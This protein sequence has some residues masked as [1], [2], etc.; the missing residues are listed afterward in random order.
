M[1]Y[2]ITLFIISSILCLGCLLTIILLMRALDPL[3]Y[4]N[5]SLRYFN[6]LKVYHIVHGGIIEQAP[7]FLFYS[8]LLCSCFVE[9]E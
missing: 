3:L 4:E 8:I 7:V 2:S 1:S 5:E 6:T 9:Q